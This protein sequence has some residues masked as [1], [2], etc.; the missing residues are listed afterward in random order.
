MSDGR[1]IRAADRPGSW[2]TEYLGDG[3]YAAY[4][5]YGMW[6]TAED[7]ITAT[8][9]IYIEPGVWEAMHRLAADYQARLRK[10][11]P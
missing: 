6:L 11:A 10:E 1:H 4:D 5:G 7:G 2:R 9:A 8:D 3:V